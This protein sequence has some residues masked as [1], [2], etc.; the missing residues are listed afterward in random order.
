[1]EHHAHGAPFFHIQHLYYAKRLP[2]APRSRV[3]LPPS[4]PLI[5]RPHAPVAERL[6]G[7]RHHVPRVHHLHQGQVPERQRDAHGARDDGG[8]LPFRLQ[9][10]PRERIQ[11]VLALG[12]LLRF[13][14]RRARVRARARGARRGAR[15]TRGAR[16]TARDSAAGI[17]RRV[18][19]CRTT[20]RARA[21][22]RRIT[23][24]GARF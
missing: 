20:A 13:G 21:T 16:N 5:R 17:A 6:L 23:R 14:E 11:P 3:S 1:M 4:R 10:L 24:R 8:E 2:R 22:T 7:R 9:R 12:R 15:A 18:A 19:K